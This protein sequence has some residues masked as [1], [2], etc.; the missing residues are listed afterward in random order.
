MGTSTEAARLM[1]QAVGSSRRTHRAGKYLRSVGAHQRNVKAR[2]DAERHDRHRHPKGLRQCEKNDGRGKHQRA[3]KHE[4]G[5]AFQAIDQ[6]TGGQG[7]DG[8]TERGHSHE[9]QGVLE[10][11]P[12]RK[13]HRSREQGEAQR[14]PGVQEVH[15]SQ[16]RESGFM[17]L[18]GSKRG[19]RRG[20]GR[21]NHQ[22]ILIR[23]R[24]RPGRPHAP[25]GRRTLEPAARNLSLTDS[26]DME[27]PAGRL[28]QSGQNH[29]GDA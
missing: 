1:A 22:E 24:L 26:S 18:P 12:P 29:A 13:Q 6:D 10:V 15:R 5:T 19:R 28:G 16:E 7:A 11:I 17:T 25:H 14:T 2:T 21:G 27:Q 20:G 8:R 23:I 4:R 3:A 9:Q